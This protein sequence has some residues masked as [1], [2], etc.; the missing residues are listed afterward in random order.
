[1]ASTTTFTISQ[2]FLGAP[3]QFNPAYGSEELEQLI[4]LYIP[5][6]GSK[7]AKLS[8]VTIDF[9][10]HATVDISNGSLVKTYIVYLPYASPASQSSSGFSP[11]VWTPSSASSS[12][13]PLVES[14]NASFSSAATAT[15][16]ASDSS[17]VKRRKNRVVKKRK[18]RKLNLNEASIPGFQ[19]MTK[20]GVDVTD[21]VGRGTKTK[22]QREHA[23]L[24]RVIKACGECRRKKV[25]VSSTFD[26]LEIVS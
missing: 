19:I 23:H 4:D 18:E 24:I 6:P 5:G 16:T 11:Q 7:Q 13:T 8:E 21:S 26:Q 1:M 17:S 14:R 22:E 9:F 20:D 2:A 12:T 25:R 3:L 15:A 10:N